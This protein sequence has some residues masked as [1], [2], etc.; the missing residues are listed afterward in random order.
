MRPSKTKGKKVKAKPLPIE[1]NQSE[2]VAL[3]KVT[4]HMHHK[5]AFML[6]FESGLRI[7]EIVNLKKEDFDFGNKQ[8]RVNMGKNSKDRIVPLPLSWKP[9]HIK[10]IPMPCKQRALQK[11]LI[12]ST[13]ETGLKAKKPK[14]HFHSLRH[15]FATECIRSGMD[16]TTVSGLL[17]HEDISTTTIYINLCPA[18]R[19]DKYRNKFGTRNK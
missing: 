9:H 4:K 19:I 3:L 17:G 12:Q 7:S 15:G 11:A 6:G 8:V 10:Y 18:E 16:I 13:E 5:I 1:I 2:Y 14:V